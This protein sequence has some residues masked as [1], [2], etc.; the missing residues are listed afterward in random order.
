MYE[1]ILAITTGLLLEI[2]IFLVLVG[3]GVLIL[4]VIPKSNH[5]IF[6]PTEYLPKDEIHTLKQVLYLS[7]MAACFITVLYIFV[8]D[9]HYFY[10]T[11]L[12]IL[13]SL[14]IGITMEKDTWPKKL[15]LILL[16]PYGSLSYMISGHPILGLADIIHVPIMVYFIKY[17]Y[18]KFTEYTETNSLGITILLLFTIVF[19]SSLNTIFVESKNPLDALV[20]SSNAFT[21]NGYAVLGESVLGKINS[22]ILVWSGFIISG[23]GTA[24]LTL[25]LSTRH[26]N[27]KF[28]E[29][30]SK[31]EELKEL[32]EE[33]KE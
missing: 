18:D 23:V 15:A 30:N 1:D 10:F 32:I 2:V 3:I 26:Y 7:L 8:F 16:V 12:D 5:R 6:N 24:T 28:D 27:K 11:A 33:K 9:G 22:L 4:K 13:L 20:M 19:F 14:Y 21:S 31:I 17:Y 25:A 29:M